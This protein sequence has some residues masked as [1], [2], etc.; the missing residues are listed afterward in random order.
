M[1]SIQNHLIFYWDIEKTLNFYHKNFWLATYSTNT[2][3][4]P[5]SQKTTPFTTPLRTALSKNPHRM[6][7]NPHR[8][9]QNPHRI[10]KTRGDPHRIKM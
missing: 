6:D 5:Q 4:P 9:E 3:G 1:S 2:T 7:K 10:K 8:I